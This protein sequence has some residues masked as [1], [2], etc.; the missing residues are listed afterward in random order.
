M[1]T[2]TPRRQDGR[3]II[4]ISG[5]HKEFRLQGQTV[6]ALRDINLDILEGEYLS[7]MGPSG[8]GKTTLFNMIGALDRPTAGRIS[9]NEVD[10][11]T[12]SSPELAFFRNNY[13]S[14]IFQA[15]N[16]LPSLTALKNV[17]LPMLFK[18]IAPREAEQ[19]AAHILE[20]VGLGERLHHRPDE[21]S[22][23]QQQ[24]VAIA[25]SLANDPLII[26]ADEPTGNLDLR[27]GEQ[28]IGILSSLSTS[29]GVTVI[30][31]THDHKMLA[32]S[33]R[34]VWISDGQIAR[35]ERREDLDI[36]VG[37]IDGSATF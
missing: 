19:K 17:A 2:D 24:R 4:R 9:I 36:Q 21:L 1:Q 8:S 20:E 30:S 13:I 18:G 31:A 32:S 11:S 6:R 16:L 5:L 14:Y 26:L 29:H 22:G 10:L 7:V 37:K 34:V 27:T 33:D 3:P 35:V 23:G 15:F 28:I 12:L 25:R